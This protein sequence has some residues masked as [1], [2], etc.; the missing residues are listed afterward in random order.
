MRRLVVAGAVLTATAWLAV[1]TTQVFAHAGLQA[2][3]P[4]ANSV[5]DSAPPAI[6]LDFDEAIEPSLASIHLYS[7][8]GREVPIDDPKAGS[9]STVVRA[10]LPSLGDGLYAVIWRVA[11]VD[12]HVVNGAFSFQI[13]DG[14]DRGGA[15]LIAA[16]EDG[17][18]AS[19]AVRAWAGI[20]RGIG[21]LCLVLLVGSGYWLTRA[22]ALGVPLGRRAKVVPIAALALVLSAAT[23]YVLFG[24]DAVAGSLGDALSPSVWGAVSDSRTGGLLKARIGFALAWCAVALSAQRLPASWRRWIE[25]ALALAVLVTFAAVGHPG[26]QAG[27]AIWVAVDMVHLASMALWLGGVI[28]LAS[29]SRAAL[30]TDN[31]TKLAK[32]FSTVALVAFPLALATGVA[33]T[34]RLGPGLGS[35]TDSEWGRELLVKIALVAAIVLLAATARFLVR[36]KSAGNLRPALLAEVA[37][38]LGV[39][40]LAASITA[41]PPATSAA[42]APFAAQLA[43]PDGLIA[44]VSLSPGAVGGNE[45]H[46]F[47]TPPGGSIVPIVSVKGRVSQASA[48]LVDVP[49]TLEREGANH[50]QGR[51][52]L[53]RSGDWELELI[54]QVR[55]GVQDVLHTTVPVP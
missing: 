48:G 46:I 2:S 31:G 14:N 20:A 35:L 53:P 27:A 22:T 5:L 45:V 15:A 47:L 21:Y 17:V 6:L 10:K 29:L 44:V 40:G 24:A 30:A 39:L 13:G 9:D 43:S 33:A 25:G 28:V 8:D 3:V 1:P 38:G 54:V 41:L 26:A 37:L 16:V 50:Y 49:I 11:S 52:T 4:A 18:Q 32:R 36:R 42:A 7:G 19:P 51:L 34:L 23:S 12:G 55:D